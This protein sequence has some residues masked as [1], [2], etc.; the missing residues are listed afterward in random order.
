MYGI[1]PLKLHL[2]Q[3][4]YGKKAAKN[5]TKFS[6]KVYIPDPGKTCTI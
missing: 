5:I 4:E 2:Y 3:S 1:R 6:K